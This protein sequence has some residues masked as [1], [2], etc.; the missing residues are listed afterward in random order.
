MSEPL[1]TAKN[2]GKNVKKKGKEEG[3]GTKYTEINGRKRERGKKEIE[4]K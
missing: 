2:K 1:I 4:Q 3:N